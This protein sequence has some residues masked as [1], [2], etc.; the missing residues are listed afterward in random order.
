MPKN[1]NTR[2]A[3]G[4]ILAGYTKPH[5]RVPNAAGQLLGGKGSLMTER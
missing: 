2:V 4:M 5:V 3:V 1:I